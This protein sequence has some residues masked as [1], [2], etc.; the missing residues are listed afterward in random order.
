MSCVSRTNSDF[1]KS[2]FKSI[3][4]NRSKCLL[5]VCGLRNAW[6][7]DVRGRILTII[8]DKH[9]I[10]QGLGDVSEWNLSRMTSPW[11]ETILKNV[12]TF[13]EPKSPQIIGICRIRI[14]KE[15]YHLV[16]SVNCTL[17]G[18]VPPE[19][20]SAQ[21]VEKRDTKRIN[22]PSQIKAAVKKESRPTKSLSIVSSTYETDRTKWRQYV[23]LKINGQEVGQH[24]DSVSGTTLISKKTWKNLGSLAVHLSNH[25]ARNASDENRQ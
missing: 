13:S 11:S 9:E 19:I 17:S 18:T 3:S 21:F 4:N 10:L 2:Y 15:N 5:F 6:Y 23:T 8:E 25:V 24:L 14:R 12:A 16:S 7:T 20:I 22:S 1:E